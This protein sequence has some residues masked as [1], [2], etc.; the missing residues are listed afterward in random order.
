[1]AA[2]GNVSLLALSFYDT[3]SNNSVLSP[4]QTLTFCKSVRREFIISD[5]DMKYVCRYEAGG[6]MLSDL[7]VSFTY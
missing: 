5:I 7:P 4:E 2:V 3:I 6:Y 1:M